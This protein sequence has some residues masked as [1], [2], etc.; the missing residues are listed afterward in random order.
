ML[1][2]TLLDPIPPD[3]ADVDCVFQ[4]MVGTVST[5]RWARFPRDGG[6]GFHGK[7]GAL[8]D[9]VKEARPTV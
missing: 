2:R 3:D 7:V 9:G 5:G 1:H 4:A 6:H 8:L